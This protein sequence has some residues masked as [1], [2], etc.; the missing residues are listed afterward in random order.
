MMANREKR[1]S[2]ILWPL[3]PLAK[4]FQYPVN[5]RLSGPC[6]WY[7]CFGK[8]TYFLCLPEIKP[9]LVQPET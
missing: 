1:Y 8:E 7:R 9:Q 3:Y 5:R 4:N 2:S 6:S